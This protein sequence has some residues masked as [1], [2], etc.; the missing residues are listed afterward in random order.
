MLPR[1]T[2]HYGVR[3]KVSATC[4]LS[5]LPAWTVEEWEGQ[6]TKEG[7]QGVVESPQEDSWGLEKEDTELEVVKPQDWVKETD[8]SER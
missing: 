5:P 1:L 8:P 3:A 4:F 6:R 7:S 2:Q